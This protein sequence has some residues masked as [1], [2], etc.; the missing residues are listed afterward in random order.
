MPRPRSSWHEQR[1]RVEGRVPIGHPL[2]DVDH[3]AS[4][5]RPVRHDPQLGRK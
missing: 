3:G 2:L 1:V 5:L 4:P